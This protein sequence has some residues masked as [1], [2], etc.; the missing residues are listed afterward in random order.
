MEEEKV[1]LEV[2]YPGVAETCSYSKG[3]QGEACIA[4]EISQEEAELYSMLSDWDEF[5]E[6]D[7]SDSDVGSYQ[8]A[9]DWKVCP[10]Q[11]L[12]QPQ[13][14]GGD[15]RRSSVQSSQE[16]DGDQDLLQYGWKETIGDKALLQEDE[17]DGI[18]ILE[19]SKDQDRE[20]GLAG[21]AGGEFL[22]PVP[23]QAWVKDEASEPCP[24][25]LLPASPLED[26]GPRVFQE[27]LQEVSILSQQRGPWKKCLSRLQRALRVLRRLFFPCQAPQP[28]D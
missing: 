25:G 22:V 11:G 1:N 28:Q 15:G 7:L 4:Q 18:S 13:L 14:S 21:L 8:E 26:R 23:C 17:W 3:S 27:Q 24:W 20:R 12:S 6:D 2:L 19:L 16:N 5:T 9:S 10:A